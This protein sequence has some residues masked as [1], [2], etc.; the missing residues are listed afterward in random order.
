MSRFFT[1]TTAWLIFTAIVMLYGFSLWALLTN[2]QAAPLFAWQEVGRILKYSLLQASLSALFSTLLGLLLAQ[3]FFYLD[4]KGKAT[5]YRL[6]SFVWALPS[7]IIIFAVIGLWGNSGWL[8]QF[9]RY[10]NLEW[11]FNI[12]GLHGI[13]LAHC[14]FNTPLITKYSLEA[15]KRIPNA[16][17]R[18]ASQ[19]NLSG[20]TYFRVVELPTLKQILPHNFMT[21]FLVCFTSFPIVLMLGGGPKYST[22][23]VAIY[24]AVSF[25]FD[26]A[27]AVMLIMVQLAMG[28]A[29][30][31][32]S[33]YFSQRALKHIH[34]T[35]PNVDLWKLTP[36]T[37]RKRFLQVNL[38][39]QI[40]GIILPLVTVIW[41]GISVS[42]L[43]EKLTNSALWEAI[44]YSLLLS[45]IATATVLFIAYFVIL[46]ARHL[47]YKKQK[48]GYA[49]L[50]GIATYPLI[51]PIFLLAAGLFL[52]LINVELTCTQ[53]LLLVGI[54]NGLTLLPFIY[55]MLFNAMWNSLTQQDKLAQSLGLTGL[56]RW[57]I[58][59]RSYLIKPLSNAAALAM[60]ASMG[61]F[62]VIAFFGSPDF[63]SLPYLLYQQL[64]SYRTEEAAVTALVLMIF[65]LLPFWFV[66]ENSKI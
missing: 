21:V 31:A 11:H 53:L 4:F 36:N 63:S 20:L 47:L 3:S 33:F 55:P 60:S 49:I 12:Y 43:V 66:K 9:A 2:R 44:R 13:I 24:Q 61:N 7:L 16:Q 38:I 32:I 10:L 64:G 59:E 51:L 40:L 37:T 17:F 54:C 57:W 6:I 62:A 18:L 27:K 19:L 34:Q 25:E 8:A 58:V 65:T 28:I 5:L 52:L 50:G 29:L 46:E 22:L 1:K 15:L 48:I 39:L 35:A 41:A 56:N 26:F 23:E 30:Q 42:N 14:L 45:A